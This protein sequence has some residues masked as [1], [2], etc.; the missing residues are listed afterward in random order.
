[1]SDV[2]ISPLYAQGNLRFNDKTRTN[3][4]NT[5]M[6]WQLLLGSE[7]ALTLAG[8]ILG[9]FW[10]VL[11]GSRWYERIRSQQSRRAVD[12]LEAG[13]DRTYETYVRAIKEAREDGK[14]TAEERRHAR[15]LAR[16]AA[17]EFGNREGIDVARELGDHFINLWIRRLLKKV[18]G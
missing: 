13:V 11:R 6:N 2:A 7:P 9:A 17:I 18:K 16:Q 1:M 10:M 4:R 15:V 3:E 8:S 5:H 12:A 14:L